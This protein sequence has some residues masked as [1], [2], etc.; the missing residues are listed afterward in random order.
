MCHREGWSNRAGNRVLA[1]REQEC[2]GDAAP[3]TSRE[4]FGPAHGQEGRRLM[5]RCAGSKWGFAPPVPGGPVHSRSAWSRHAMR[6]QEKADTV[7]PGR[8]ARVACGVGPCVRKKGELVPCSVGRKGGPHTAGARGGLSGMCRNGCARAAWAGTGF[9]ASRFGEMDGG[10]IPGGKRKRARGTPLAQDVGARAAGG[11][12]PH[13]RK[14]RDL[15]P[16]SVGGWVMRGACRWTLHP[17]ESE[18]HPACRENGGKHLSPQEKLVPHARLVDS[19]TSG[20]G[21]GTRYGCCELSGGWEGR[22][23]V[24]LGRLPPA[25]VE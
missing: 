20:S 4:G 12:G 7:H 6:V 3:C 8:E 10:L 15:A 25:R 13:V 19:S 9:R 1:S 18:A 14:K 24:H 2:D 16:C 17:R 23:E 21:D 22:G 11:W 5:P